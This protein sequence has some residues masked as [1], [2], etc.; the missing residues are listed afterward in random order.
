[1]PDVK[2][3][4]SGKPEMQNQ[5]LIIGAGGI[6][7]DAHLPAY[8]KAG[9]PVFG[10]VDIVKEKASILAEKYHIPNVFSNIEDA[11]KNAPKDVVYDLALN[12]DQHLNVVK[13][14]PDYSKVLLQKP[15][16]ASSDEAKVLL[17]LCHS[18]NLLAAVNFQ[19][20]FAPFVLEA[21]GLMDSGVIGEIY[22][23]EIR[24]TTHTPWQFFPG[25]AGKDRLEIVYHSIHYIDLIR[26]FLGEPKAVLAKSFGHPLKPFSSTRSTILLDYG[27]NIR[28]VINTNHD[29][30]FGSEH[31]ESFIKWEG[32]K[33]AIK[34]KMG[35][36]MDYPNG[37][38]DQLEYC[39]LD[40][41][42]KP[43]WKNIE[44]KGNWFP[45]AFAGIM[46]QLMHFDKGKSE[47]LLTHVDDAFKTMKLVEKCF[48]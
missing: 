20:R 34:A 25:L 24:L 29:H 22:D 36:L 32:T 5:I 39:F 18:K 15:L 6:V 2:A 1:M 47:K 45:D 48:H 12:P 16:G 41:D 43:E 14:L 30:D 40:Q 8:K 27:R 17:N 19:L 37:A 21:R 28:A 3:Y 46:S 10:I 23:M 9:F 35:V 44:L 38:A 4:H 7:K 31:Q 13:L 26:S 33:G 42:V 11:V